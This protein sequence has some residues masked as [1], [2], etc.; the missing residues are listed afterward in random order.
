[1]HRVDKGSTINDQEP[2]IYSNL[3]IQRY[4]LLTYLF[5]ASGSCFSQDIDDKKRTIIKGV[6]TDLVLDYLDRD[7]ATQMSEYI[8][9]KYTSEGYDSTL[10]LDEFTYEVTNDLRNI[11]KDEHLYVA[12]LHRKLRLD[13]RKNSYRNIRIG[14]SGR[15]IIPIRYKVR[16]FFQ[17]VRWYFRYKKYLRRLGRDK[18]SYGEIKILP[19]NIGYFELFNF[20]ASS[21]YRRENKGRVKLKKVLKFLSNTNSVIIDLRNNTGGYIKMAEYFVANFVNYPESYF[22]TTETR[23]VVDSVTSERDSIYTRKWITPKLKNKKMRG[24]ALYVLTSRY[25]FSAAEATTYFLKKKTNATIIGETTR[26]GGNG[27]FG[28]WYR[29]YYTIVVPRIRVYD[30]ELNYSWEAKGIKPDIHSEYDSAF[31]AAY[32][33]ALDSAGVD[34]LILKTKVFSKSQSK[35]ESKTFRYRSKFGLDTYCGAYRRVV[36]YQ[37]GPNIY[38][39]YDKSPPVKLIPR[40]NDKFY[41]DKFK[42]VRFKRDDDGEISAINLRWLDGYIEKYRRQKEPSATI[43]Q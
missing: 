24:K 41:A 20:D 34:S 26:G 6:G 30:E 35:L 13:K 3:N 31:N 39:E 36:V 40:A 18:F 37:K 21:Y 38:M 12:V 11:S 14:R 28:G 8:N 5:I 15:V 42:Y 16:N 22:L 2:V 9:T 32:A 23:V 25:T 33:I 7:K 1:M 43:K 29:K 10:N 27:H 19:G 17:R 4:L